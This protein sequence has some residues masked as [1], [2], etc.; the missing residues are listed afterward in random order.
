M[1]ATMSR[2]KSHKSL[3]EAITLLYMLDKSPESP[4][5]N[6]PPQSLSVPSSK[7][8]LPFQREK[9]IVEN[10]AFLSATTDDSDRVMAVCLEEADDRGSCRIRLTSN[11]GDTE[12]VVL[13]F[14]LMAKVLEQAASRGSPPTFHQHS[15]IELMLSQRTAKMMMRRLCF[16]A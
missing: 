9:Q 15:D 6:Q 12:K 2:G 13:G 4:K 8:Q 14:K 1:N 16:D 5:D 11:L 3:M 10:L 7:Y